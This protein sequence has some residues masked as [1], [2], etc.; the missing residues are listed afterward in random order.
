MTHINRTALSAGILALT[1][2]FGMTSAALA[3]LP[4]T[5]GA[6][7]PRPPVRPPVAKTP[8]TINPGT[9]PIT[10]LPNRLVNP[11]LATPGLTS[12]L[13][14]PL[15]TLPGTYPAY[16][17]LTYPYNPY[18]PLGYSQYV[19]PYATPYT[20]MPSVTPYGS[21]LVNPYSY[22]SPYATVNPLTAALSNPFVAAPGP[23]LT[24]AQWKNQLVPAYLAGSVINAAHAVHQSVAGNVFAVELGS[25]RREPKRARG[26]RLSLAAFCDTGGALRHAAGSAMLGE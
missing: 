18:L 11:T 19:N 17:T 24:Y 13:T 7:Q 5:R 25:Y 12:P 9:S 1:S 4:T 22:I 3:Q 10:P 6:T 2:W 26:P 20:N 8:P 15:G 23:Y 16:N 21:P 14:N